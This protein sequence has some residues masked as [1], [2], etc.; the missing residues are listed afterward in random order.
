MESIWLKTAKLPAFQPLA[1]DKKTDVLIIGGGIA[2]ILT[3]LTMKQAGISCVLLEVGRILRGTTGHT[4]AKLT[5]QH[6]LIYAKL[7]RRLGP[8][9]AK[10]YYLANEEAIA[11]F[12]ELARDIPCGFERRDSFIYSVDRPDKLEHELEALQKLDIPA[13]LLPCPELPMKTA[14]G[15]CFH[16]QAQFHP[17]ELLAK[18]SAGLE[19]FERSRAL[20]YDG[21][22]V[23]TDR[24]RIKAEHIVVAT[25]FPIFNKH[26]AYFLK[27]YQSRSYVLALKNAQDVNGMYLD[28]AEGGLSFRNH[29][30]Y[31]L[32]GGGAHRPGKHSAGWAG[33]EAFAA[34][35]Y[36]EAEI[37]ARWAAQDCM[38]L[39][40]V[41]Y[42]G[43]Y[44]RG[45]QRLYVAT[46]FNKW[47]MSSSMAAA[48]LLTD[49]VLGRANPYEELFSPQRG[50]LSPQLCVN[51]MEAALNRITPTAPRCPHM[52]CALKWNRHERSWDCPCHGSR[53]GPDGTVLDGPANGD[54][55]VK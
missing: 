36:P 47:G 11:R 44:G 12:D 48:G 31:L 52:G 19:I 20:A 38:S 29:G 18:V 6:G 42:I 46:G 32:L 51:S 53:F 17:L 1:G 39:D 3:A 10:G 2:G 49:M 4:T 5:S 14:G 50:M 35:H 7:L 45:P 8:E 26:G 27:L 33:L 34:L 41:P 37:A 13:E 43:R 55:D 30:E 15:L 23:V 16:D 22:S 9:L 28:E 24:G 21:E 54:M 40:A 25:H